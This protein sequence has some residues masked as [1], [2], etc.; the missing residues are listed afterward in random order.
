MSDQNIF[1]DIQFAILKMDISSMINLLNDCFDGLDKLQKTYPEVQE[2]IRYNLAKNTC[3]LNN[4]T[5]QLMNYVFTAYNINQSNYLI[6]N[7]QKGG[8][9]PVG[10]EI[11]KKCDPNI[12]ECKASTIISRNTDNITYNQQNYVST[13][14]IGTD[15]PILAIANNSQAIAALG[16]DGINKFLDIAGKYAERDLLIAQTEANIKQ[17][18]QRFKNMIRYGGITFSIGAPGALCYYLQQ[19]VQ[20]TAVNVVNIAGSIAGSTVGNVELIGRNIGPYFV[21]TL[22]NAG[23]LVKDW[24]PESLIMLGKQLKETSVAKYATESVA[25]QTISAVTTSAISTTTDAIIFANI[26]IYIVGMIL[27]LLL[28]CVIYHL[29]TADKVGFYIG[30]PGV[31]NVAIS[32][33]ST[34]K[35]GKKTRKNKNINNKK[36]KTHKKY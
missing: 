25:Q 15:N 30:V 2:N 22:L 3:V 29:Y 11:V 18:E 32:K 19:I 6:Q 28:F 33:D 1:D 7:I 26:I 21:N 12:E 36:R 4:D 34:K 13:N 10:Q 24:A 14:V 8:M 17:S 5:L 9:P 27:L 31:T 16:P 35:G 23:K 20:G